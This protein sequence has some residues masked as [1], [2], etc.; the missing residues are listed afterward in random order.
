MRVR[1]LIVSDQHALKKLGIRD[2]IP[3]L[4]KV[5][6]YFPKNQGGVLLSTDFETEPGTAL[7]WLPS[8][9]S[10]DM[11]FLIVKRGHLSNPDVGLQID[12]CLRTLDADGKKALLLAK[13]PQGEPGLY[14]EMKYDHV[15]SIRAYWAIVMKSGLDDDDKQALLT[16]KSDKG[17]SALRITFDS[18]NHDSMITY[19]EL[20]LNSPFPDKVKQSM[21][22]SAVNGKSIMQSQLG[23]DQ[24]MVMLYKNAIM[25]SSLD[26]KVKES[27]LSE[28]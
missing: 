27:L 16:A 23:F 15:L 20:V 1:R 22:A 10:H 9:V 12:N 25:H 3:D 21:L 13:S 2:L 11:M 19:V 28:E 5:V 6:L 26:E 17:I 18:G 8:E 14:R 7:V 24:E 4:H